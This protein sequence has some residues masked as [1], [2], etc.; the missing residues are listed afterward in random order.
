[1]VLQEIVLF[2][3]V[4]DSTRTVG[5]KQEESLSSNEKI[6]LAPLVWPYQ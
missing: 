5:R 6:I 1:M 4:P 3:L 2:F